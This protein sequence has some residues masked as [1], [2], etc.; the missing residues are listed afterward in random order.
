MSAINTGNSELNQEVETWLH[1]E[2]N[3]INRREVEEL[4]KVND[5]VKLSKY[6]FNRLQFG[7]AGLRGVMAAGPSNMND[8]TIIQTSQGIAKYLQAFFNDITT[9][10]IVIGYDGRHN[11]SRFAT[12]ATR[13]FVSMG[14]PVKLFSDLVPTPY[15]PFSVCHFKAKAG[16]MITASHNP[17][18]D[19]GYKVYWENGAQIIPPHDKNI[20]KYILENLVP[21]DEAW[22]ESLISSHSLV[23]DP[24]SEVNHHY[25]DVLTKEC[26]LSNLNDLTNLKFTYTPVHGVGGPYVKKVFEVC[27]FKPFIPVIE[28]IDPD[29][30]FPTV[31]FPNPEEGKST[32]NLAL[33]T[34]NRHQSSI[35]LANDP[36]ADRLA[37]AELQSNGEWKVFTGNELGALLGW[38]MW[39]RAQQ[40]GVDPSKAVMISSTVSSK[41]LESMAKK[42]GFIFEETLTGF[43]WMANRGL[44]LQEQ[45]HQ[46]LFAFEE[47]IGFM[48]GMHVPDKD[49]ISA[50]A[51]L[52]EMAVYLQS[53]FEG[54]TLT[55]QL[56]EIY[57]RYGY[58]VTINSYFL[59]YDPPT[60][61]RIFERLRN[62]CDAPKTY[63]QSLRGGLYPLTG[64]RDLTTGF[65]SRQA[66]GR[67][68]LP[69]S[70]SSQMIT[71]YFDNGL[72]AT[73]R[74]SGT[75]PKIKY[76]T[77]LRSAPGTRNRFEVETLLRDMVESLIDEFIQPQLNHLVP[78]PE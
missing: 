13:A 29:P 24:L 70:A 6:F 11:S 12:L 33:D 50:V 62:F 2:K 10:G 53:E 67:A 52:T 37:C 57:L 43:K 16:I 58:H 21:W 42:E 20:Q 9:Y 23:L 76:Y 60:I 1:W 48:C 31:V 8:L 64:V 47:A 45:G 71:F 73:I 75:E 19:N 22:D 41:F 5:V 63:P 72:D 51:H 27:G 36:D 15:I 65:D 25:Y 34:A 49:G 55:Q 61:T 59:C 17:K 66:D 54:R 39:H 7:T 46:V 74:T 44:E 40:K 78:R 26:R 28:Q 30:E 38:W 32:L 4:L 35:V 3:E 14:I 69:S 68:K 77:E 18:N 56:Q